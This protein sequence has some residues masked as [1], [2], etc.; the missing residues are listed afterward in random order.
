MTQ[1][2]FRGLKAGATLFSPAILVPTPGSCY[3]ESV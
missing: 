3:T 2:R 1:Q